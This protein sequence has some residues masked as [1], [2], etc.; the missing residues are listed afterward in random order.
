M[1][2]TLTIWPPGAGQAKVFRRA[3]SDAVIGAQSSDPTRFKS[4]PTVAASGLVSACTFHQPHCHHQ[5][6]VTFN[7]TFRSRRRKDWQ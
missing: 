3:G 5:G 7:R 4:G 2:M 1:S 6:D